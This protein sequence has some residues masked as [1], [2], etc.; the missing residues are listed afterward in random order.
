MTQITINRAAVEDVETIQAIGRQ[1]FSETFAKSNTEEDMQKYL[2]ENFSTGKIY[3]ELKNPDSLFFIAWEENAAIG[4]LKLNTGK[5]QTELQDDTAIEIERIYVKG[6]YHGK[7]VGQMLYEKAIEIARLQRRSYI[8]LAVWEEN[9]RAIS[10]YKKNGFV[11]FD[12][13]I[14]KL[15]NDEQVDIM[16]KK[17]IDK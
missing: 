4:Y 1:T 14:F 5:A 13:H 17:A 15:G 6:E 12:Q 2:D 3:A 10:F 9:A 16:M 11:E 7:K 8:W